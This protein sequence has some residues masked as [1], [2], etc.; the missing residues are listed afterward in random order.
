MSRRPWMAASDLAAIEECDKLR[1]PTKRLDAGV[2]VQDCREAWM[3]DAKLTW[4]Y[5]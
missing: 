4:R 2:S 1:S 5:L 3:P